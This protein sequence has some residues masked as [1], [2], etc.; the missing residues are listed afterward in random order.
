MNKPRERMSSI[1]SRIG[2]LIAEALIGSIEPQEAGEQLTRLFSE[3]AARDRGTAGQ[4]VRVPLAQAQ[5]LGLCA[6]AVKQRAA[7]IEEKARAQAQAKFTQSASDSPQ[8]A[9]DRDDPPAA[10]ELE[11]RHCS[12]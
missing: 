10:R 7:A 4:D 6:I 5:R 3:A 2:E 11:C 12:S 1:V 9:N 8:P